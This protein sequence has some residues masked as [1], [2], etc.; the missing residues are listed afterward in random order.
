MKHLKVLV[1][2]STGSMLIHNIEL[3]LGKQ[4]Q[5]RFFTKGNVEDFDIV[6]IQFNYYLENIDKI[7]NSSLKKPNI[8]ILANFTDNSLL[9]KILGDL[10]PYHLIGLTDLNAISDLKDFLLSF[11]ENKEWTSK[12]FISTPFEHN[13]LKIIDSLDYQEKIEQIINRM[14]LTDCFSEFNTYLSQITNE[15][16]T[17]ALFNAPVDDNGNFLYQN[18]S[19]NQNISMVPGKEVTLEVLENNKKIII[20]VKDNYGSLTKEAIDQ[21]INN[22]SVIQ[23]DG[24]AG[25]GLYTTF[26]YCHKLIFNINR[27]KSTEVVVVLNKLKRNKQYSLIDKSFHYFER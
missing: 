6:L 25:I 19:R 12:L 20:S 18:L 3:A 22:A 17:N 5:F 10:T 9:D 23:K 16:I 11:S 2:S 24:G 1:L 4:D 7:E 21:F 15:L 8:A 27:D 13:S 14:N 26:R